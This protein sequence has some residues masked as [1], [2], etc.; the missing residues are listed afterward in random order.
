MPLPN[1]RSLCD[2]RVPERG[3][4]ARLLMADIV[5]MLVDLNNETF[6]SNG[7]T[8]RMLWWIVSYYLHHLED[9][10]DRE[11]SQF[12]V[13]AGVMATLYLLL[14]SANP[15]KYFI[16]RLA[17]LLSFLSFEFCLPHAPPDPSVRCP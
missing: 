10:D 16:G 1:C 2:R 11:D 15:F 3:V 4:L 13:S 12:C 8:T 14:S 6:M 17:V 7:K 9:G 5:L